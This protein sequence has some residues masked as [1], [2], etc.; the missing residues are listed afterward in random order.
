MLSVCIP[1][2]NFQNPLLFK[3]IL[4]QCKQLSLNFEILSI[5]DASD[6]VHQQYLKK[7]SISDYRVLILEE[8]IG[9]AA[10]RNLL[11]KKA[12]HE[13][14]LFLDGDSFINEKNFISNY[15]GALN[16]D[17]ISG[18]RKYDEY[19][20]ETAYLMH[21]SYGYTIESKAKALFHS[22]NFMIK[23]SVFE[24]LKFEEKIRTYGYEDVVFGIEAKKKGLKIICIDNPVIHTQLKTDAEF[25][26]DAKQALYN[27]IQIE[28][29]RADLGIE[30]E[31]TLLKKYSQ[32]EKWN[33]NWVWSIGNK[34]ILNLLAK[35]LSN[36]RKFNNKWLMLFKLYYLHQL[37]EQL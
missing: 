5:D 26:E 19:A 15:L 28:K 12:K 32:F 2:F 13:W 11:A 35:K 27:L 17:V 16:A 30:N 20:P 22:N 9:R 10:I 21:W 3:D 18:G 36:S 1:H 4:S 14:L 29:L 37:K 33:I 31:V 34:T 6:Y 8:N 23:K 25:L 7:L 24:T